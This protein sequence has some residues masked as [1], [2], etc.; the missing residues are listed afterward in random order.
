MR[1]RRAPFSLPCSCPA[2]SADVVAVRALDP[3]GAICAY[4]LEVA[5]EWQT[6]CMEQPWLHDMEAHLTTL[7]LVLQSCATWKL[8]STETFLSDTWPPFPS[9]I[10]NGPMQEPGGDSVDWETAG[11]CDGQRGCA[12]NPSN[13]RSTMIVYASTCC[14]EGF[15]VLHLYC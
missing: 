3:R 5:L 7:S 9:I 14:V 10:W 12:D 13:A 2:C 1:N 15:M 11:H 4:L 6:V 8:P